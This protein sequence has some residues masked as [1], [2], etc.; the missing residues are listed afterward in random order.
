MNKP[1][2]LTPPPV[3]RRE[4]LAAGAAVMLPVSGLAAQPAWPNKL[5]RLVVPSAAGSP[6]DPV[7]RHLADRLSKAFGQP[8]IVD[9]KSGATGLIG[10][11]Q[12]AKSNDGHT[13]GVMFLPHALLPALHPKMPYDT[14]KDLVPVAQTQWTYHVLVTRPDLGAKSVRD[15]VALVRA[16]PGKLS[17]SSGG[18][19]SP[20][21]VMGEY[22]VQT[23]GIKAVHV[24]YRGP[25][26]ALQDLMGGQ[27]DM[28]FASVA[29]AAP[30]VQSGRLQALAV[31]APQSLAA[32]PA[33]P[34]FS[35]AGYPQ[36]NV[37]DWAGIVASK[38]VPKDAIP[39]LHAAIAQAL[40][41]PGVPERFAK[42]GTYLQVSSPAQFQQLIQAE[43]PKW[44]D[45]VQRANIQMD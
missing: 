36:F 11:E 33:V 41:E 17:F 15:L 26:A 5:V 39:R 7:A 18:N 27:G 20:A 22:F 31:T 42:L 16:Q 6:W 2:T 25:V 9:N 40:S 30:H 35:A 13:L 8:F 34:S 43:L 38:S 21:H 10:M 14:L 37:R 29:A 4:L 3:R 28:M 45:V 32:L 1:S 19:G 12:V 23:T 24:P 44:R